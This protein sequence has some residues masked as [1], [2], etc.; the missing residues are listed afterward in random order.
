[1]HAEEVAKILLQNIVQGKHEGDDLYSEFS[2]FLPCLCRDEEGWPS[3]KLSVC[4]GENLGLG[5][6][7]HMTNKK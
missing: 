7:V 1:M 3:L 6:K 4:M 2:A 5:K